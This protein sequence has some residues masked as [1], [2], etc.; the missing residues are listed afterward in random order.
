MH[1]DRDKQAALKADYK[2]TASLPDGHGGTKSQD[3]IGTLPKIFTDV[4]NELVKQTI[5]EKKG[6]LFGKFIFKMLDDGLSF[7]EVKRQNSRELNLFKTQVLN[8][9]SPRLQEIANELFGLYN[10]EQSKIN[11]HDNDMKIPPPFTGVVQET[12]NKLL[13]NG[14][15]QSA[16]YQNPNGS[17]PIKWQGNVLPAQAPTSAPAPAPGSP[18]RR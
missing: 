15:T 8:Q 5:E 13:S 11:K 18:V 6:Q 10:Q 1:A 12:F 2:Y 4:V 17:Q 14:A 7:S 16:P 3:F 9:L